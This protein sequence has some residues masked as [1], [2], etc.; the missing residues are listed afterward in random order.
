MFYETT[1]VLQLRFGDIVEGFP[2][3]APHIPATESGRTPAN[4]RMEVAC[5]ALAALAMG[6]AGCNKEAKEGEAGGSAAIVNTKCPMMPTRDVPAD[7]ELT[8][9]FQGKTVGFCCAGCPAKWDALSDE[10]KAT[11]LAA[12][13]G[14]D[15]GAAQCS[16]EEG[17]QCAKCVAEEAVECTGEEDCQCAR[18]AAEGEAEV[19]QCTSQP[20]CECPHCA[21]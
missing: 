18:C 6:L 13:C 3:V 17:C 8:R 4:Y 12:V 14:C 21:S 7:T 20:D 10:E 5:F 16:G 11:R 19:V 2:L 9:T 1:S 15:A